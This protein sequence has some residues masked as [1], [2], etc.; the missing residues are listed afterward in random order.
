MLRTS[1]HLLALFFLFSFIALLLV[2]LVAGGVLIWVWSDLC[3][4]DLFYKSL[5]PDGRYQA[6]VFQRDCGATTSFTTHVA[7]LDV[8]DSFTDH[9][10]GNIFMM[11][12]HPDDTQV[13]AQWNSS[14]E[15]T[16]SYQEG[17]KIFLQ[18]DRFQ[19]ITIHY[20]PIPPPKAQGSHLL[21]GVHLF[22]PLIFRAQSFFQPHLWLIA[23]HL[24]RTG[25]V[26]PGVAHIARLLPHS[27]DSH[28]LAH[29]A[30]KHFQ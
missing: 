22:D 8:D 15:L 16:I 21:R 13:L 29:Y 11:D 28:W 27:L 1:I 3:G 30:R 19:D 4:N 5:S 10:K 2:A 24:L 25:D 9:T 7:L 12:G 6:V 14:Q 23:Q 20:I 18:K 17:Y 26:G